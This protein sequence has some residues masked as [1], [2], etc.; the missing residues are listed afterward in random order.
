MHRFHEKK[1]RNEPHRAASL[2]PMMQRAPHE[3]P[4]HGRAPRFRSLPCARI[5]LVAFAAS[6]RLSAQGAPVKPDGESDSKALAWFEHRSA[7]AQ[8]RIL[9]SVRKALEESS[10]PELAHWRALA[11]RAAASPKSKEIEVKSKASPEGARALA[12]ELPFPIYTEYVFGARS[13]RPALGANHKPKDAKHRAVEE[14]QALLAGYPPNLDLAF[15]ECLAAVNRDTA[16]DEF[17]LFLETWRN[18]EESFYRALD[19]TAGTPG[20]VFFFDAMLSD[21]TTKFVK[22]DDGKATNLKWSLNAAHDALHDSFLAYRQYRAFREAFALSIFLAPDAR[23]PESLR[24]YE[25]AREGLF[26][27]RDHVEMLLALS[28]GDPEPAIALLTS[29]A[30]PLPRPLWSAKYEPLEPFF[31]AFAAKLPEIQ[32]AFG[33]PKGAL[34]ARRKSRAELA[35]SVSGIARKALADAGCPALKDKTH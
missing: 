15:A 14:M 3:G 31:A 26:S 4:N 18:G 30:P 11:S 29:T 12:A 1:G 19:R 5:A 33:S 16:A 6:G 35:A 32:A 20:G 2:V 17:A 34:D 23:L 21:F 22:S 25:T 24:R 13:I 10:I 28:K 8:K 9:A 7:D 27:L